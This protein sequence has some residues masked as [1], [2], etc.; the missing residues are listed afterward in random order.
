MTKMNDAFVALSKAYA[1]T[2]TD[3][4]PRY[5]ELRE[6]NVVYEGDLVS[7]LG[8]PSLVAGRT[9]D[10]KVF[11]FL[12]HEIC[13]KALLDPATYSSVIYK[14]AFGGVMGDPVILYQEGDEHRAHRSILAKILSPAALKQMSDAHFKPTIQGMVKA[15]AN[16]GKG[17]LMSDLILDFPLRVVYKLFGLPNDDPEAMDLFNTRALVMVLG[18]MCDFSKPEEAQQ[19]I[20]NAFKA[21]GEIYDQILEV[22]VARRAAGD[23]EGNDLIAQL[24][25]LDNDGKKLSDE[26]IAQV[27]RPTMA[28]AGETTSR[29]LAN[30]I[31]LLLERPALLEEVR[32]DRSLVKAAMEEAM[33][34]EGAVSIVPRITLQDTEVAGVKIPAGS[35]VSMLVG[36]ANRDPAVHE[37]PDEYDIR[38]KRSKQAM[39]FGF[40][41]HMCMGMPLA[42]IEMEIAINAILD[43]LP[44]LRLDPKGGYEGIRGIQFRSPTAIPVLWDAG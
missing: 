19:R 29:A 20:A 25:R 8:V 26:E 24:I 2:M 28:A 40:G 22:V 4:Y 27:L 33:R 13:S 39:S 17:E 9:G 3:P 16:R 1:G 23:T 7:E 10:R 15:I 18:G 35:G 42:K 38:V 41:H 36:A 30:V 43:Y 31:S 37:N 32:S 11:T 34:Y 44:N 21:S 12:G 6:K 14:E 5:K